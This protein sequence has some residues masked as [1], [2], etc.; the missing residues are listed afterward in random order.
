MGRMTSAWAS[1]TSTSGPQAG[2]TIGEL[3]RDYRA[4]R[5]TPREI[6]ARVRTE[7]AERGDDGVWI[8]VAAEAEVAGALRRA[9]RARPERAAAVRHPVRGQ[10]QHRRR[11]L[12]D[13]AGLPG[14][15]LRRRA[16]RAGGRSGCSTPGAV[17]VGKTN[18]DQF[19]TGLNGTR[20]PYPI[21][22]SVFGSDLISG[23][24]SSGS[25]LAVA[26]R[27]GAV[28]GGHRHRRLGP[29]AAGT[30]RDRR[31]QAV[32]RADQHRRPGAGLPLA[33]LHQPD[34]R[35]RRR[36]RA[37][38]F[39]VVAAPDDRDPWSRTAAPYEPSTW[40]RSGSACPTFAELEFFGDDAMAR[41]P[42][43][44]PRAARAERSPRSRRAAGARS[45]PPASC[46][47]GPGWPSGW[48]SSAT[49][50][51]STPTRCYPVIADD[52]QR[53]RAVHRGRRVP[54]AVP[55]GRAQG[56]RRPR[57]SPTMDVLVVPTIGTTFTVDEVLADPIDDQHQA[58]PLHPLRQP[59]RPVRRRGA[60][61][62]PPADG[63]PA[64]CMV[65]GPALADDTVLA[66]AA[67][68]ARTSLLAP[69]IRADYV[70]T[71][72]QGATSM[73]Q[74]LTDID[75]HASTPTAGRSRCRPARWRWS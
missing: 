34:G 42:P 58:R 63:R 33:G 27:R 37:A 72:P 62:A 29:G 21:P 48:S 9:R 74:S 32:P 69:P 50:S 26:A 1:R 18:L 24:S 7:I 65:L 53:R 10:G 31:L 15:R 36:P 57:C 66:V 30:Q 44:R 39:D 14:L 17:L 43:E 71:H 40:P 70:A 23:G 13:H 28:R 52:H 16:D 5:S 60:R 22:R 75:A 38:C 51:P 19:A 12:A 56:R 2:P 47:T 46:S 4:G 73:T 8:S 55:A 68:I 6:V 41:G 61:P 54:R 35:H 3:L 25:A 20:T 11:R 67:Q 59:A 45:W 64:S 49:S